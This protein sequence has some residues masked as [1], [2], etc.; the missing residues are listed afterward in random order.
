MLLIAVGWCWVGWK[1]PSLITRGSLVQV[2]VATLF[3]NTGSYMNS[4][5]DF[6]EAN[7]DLLLS[8]ETLIVYAYKQNPKM[9]DHDVIKVMDQVIKYFRA[10]ATNFPFE[11]HIFLSDLENELY[12]SIKLNLEKKISFQ[13]AYEL[14]KFLKKSVEL[15]NKKGGSQGYLTYVTRFLDVE[16]AESV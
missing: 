3:S 12:T 16:I 8:I 9:H 11:E 6:I 5:S 1:S 2:Q 14:L 4:K 7:Y 13:E 10:K 15:W